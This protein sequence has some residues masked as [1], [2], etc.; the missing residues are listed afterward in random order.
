[1][2]EESISIDLGMFTREQLEHLIQRSCEED[3]S[4]NK[5][6]ENILKEMMGELDGV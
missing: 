2:E 5:I 4:I 3:V 6:I 1:M